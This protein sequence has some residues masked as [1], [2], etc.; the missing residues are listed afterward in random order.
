MKLALALI[1]KGDNKEAECLQR[2]L[3]YTAPFVDGIFVT[4]TQ[5]NKNIKEIANKYNANVS[6]YKWDYNFANARNFNF[7]QIPKEYTHILW[8]DSDDL[9][10]GLKNLRKTIERNPDV[11]IFTMNYL[12]WFDKNNNP[13]VVHI[14][15]QVIKNDNC[16]EWRGEIHEDFKENRE[17]VIK[18]LKGIERL[19]LSDDKRLEDNKLR[20]LNISERALKNN[21][22]DPRNWWNLA[23]AQRATGRH[24]DESIKTFEKFIKMS[25]SE[26]EKYLSFLRISEV[27][28]I[29]K[30][31]IKALDSIRYAIGTKPEYPDAYIMCGHIYFEM[32]NFEEA[33]FFYSA[34]LTRKAPVYSILVYNPRDYDYVPL[35]AL[36]KTYL[37]LQLPT[38]AVECLKACSEIMPEDESIKKTIKLMDSEVNK[39]NSVIKNLKKLDKIKNKN[40]LKEAIDNLPNEVKSHPAICNLRNINFIKKTS[41][42]KDLVFYCGFTTEEWTPETLKT[43][44]IGGSEEAI[45]NLSELL[46]KRGWNVSVY[47]N[48]GSQEKKFNGV[49]YKPFWAW[50]YRDKQDI[51]VIWR[52]PKPVEYEINAEKVYIDLHDVVGCGEFNEK[53]MKYIHKIFVKSK[54]HRDLYPN[55]PDD[56]FIIVPNG[57]DTYLFDQEAKRNPYYLVNF[58]SPDRSLETILD[59]LP[60]V[61]RRLPK[62]IAKKVKFGWF[63]GWGVFNSS[64][65]S[66]QEQEWKQSIVKRFEELKKQ[67]IAIGGYRISHQEIAKHSLVAGAL[68]YPTEFYE[69]D[70]VGGSKCQLAGCLPITTDFAALKDKIK[71]GIKIHSDKTKDNWTDGVSCNFG[72]R[73]KIKKGMFIDA[74]VGYLKNPDKWNEERKKMSDW[75]KNEFNK[76]R[77]ADIWDK[78]LLKPILKLVHV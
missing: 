66:E 1:V 31:Y 51:V 49:T 30:N 67:G 59:I 57:I 16:V 42:G 69:I 71:F 33:K 7:K 27:Y 53:R 36:A 45:I 3:N 29:Q 78:E 34:S 54:A 52:H 13:T 26:E 48:C 18:F 19:H 74:L 21:S 8:M 62:N 68:I 28:L 73:D 56:K 37:N 43:K 24:Y 40:R 76:E 61:I 17:L 2:A 77:I 60:E 63:Y 65:T 14:K 6:Y 47:N 10:R 50:N 75:A 22:K 58:S 32:G 55:L 39:F 23:N 9:F 25:R 72:I 44:G 4:I 20:N 41:S 5:P 64:N 15:S 70:Y 11:D 35:M 38:L 12:Y 46:A